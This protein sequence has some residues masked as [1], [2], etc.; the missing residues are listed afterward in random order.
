MGA[1]D[2]DMNFLVGNDLGNAVYSQWLR[3]TLSEE[4]WNRAFDH[5]RLVNEERA[6]DA[7]K[8][9]LA[10]L[11]LTTIFSM[12]F[13]FWGDPFENC[14]GLEQSIRSFSTS[15]G[16]LP[17]VGSQRSPPSAPMSPEVPQMP[18]RLAAVLGNPA[19]IAN[20]EEYYVTLKRMKDGPVD[21]ASVVKEEPN[22]E[23]IIDVSAEP[24]VANATSQ[25]DERRRGRCAAGRC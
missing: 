14:A 4:Q 13:R 15:A 17:A 8:V 2:Y 25:D 10:R 3:P 9:C 22:N 21:P 11:Y 24:G 6:G 23:N 7:M 18:Q 19:V 1:N 16:P 5:P 20:W 12:E